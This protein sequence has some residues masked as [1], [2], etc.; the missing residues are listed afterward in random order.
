MCYKSK[1]LLFENTQKD[2]ILYSIRLNYCE[3]SS[4]GH[5]FWASNNYP[6]AKFKIIVIYIQQ[7][8][9]PFERHLKLMWIQKAEK[10][11]WQI[12]VL[13]KLTSVYSALLVH[14][15]KYV[16]KQKNNAS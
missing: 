11:T 12:H 13:H 8:V 16:K 4:W 6:L 1:Q 10:N 15:L 3:E 7:L 2:V 9:F 5:L 14:L